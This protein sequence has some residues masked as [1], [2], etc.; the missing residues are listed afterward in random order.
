MYYYLSK[1]LFKQLI[2]SNVCELL[3]VA[4]GWYRIMLQNAALAS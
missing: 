2:H 1:T 4:N 3:L